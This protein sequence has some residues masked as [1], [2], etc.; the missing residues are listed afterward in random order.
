ML[1]AG[2]MSEIKDLRFGSIR[3]SFERIHP[4]RL[5]ENKQVGNRHNEDDCGHHFRYPLLATFGRALLPHHSTS[6]CRSVPP[7]VGAKRETGAKRLLPLAVLNA[8]SIQG[9]QKS[10]S[11]PKR[12]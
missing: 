2:G 3:D 7:A 11:I 6:P 5:R 4:L 1:E 12:L 8:E 9:R 10:S